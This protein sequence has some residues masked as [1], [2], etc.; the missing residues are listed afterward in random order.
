M[1][2]GHL[3]KLQVRRL[4]RRNLPTRELGETKVELTAAG[5]VAGTRVL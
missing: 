1:L 4:A 2:I 5:R 3:H